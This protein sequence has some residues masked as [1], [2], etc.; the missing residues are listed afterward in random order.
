MKLSRQLL[1]DGLVV[2]A[3]V[4][5]SSLS[6]A[7]STPI[8]SANRKSGSIVTAQKAEGAHGSSITT[9]PLH[10]SHGSSGQ[11]PLYEPKDKAAAKPGRGTTEAQPYKDPEDMT[12]R[13][14]P[15]NN[16]TTRTP[17]NTATQGAGSQR[18]DGS[19]IHSDFPRSADRNSAHATESL[20]PSNKA[21]TG[22]NPLYEGGG[23]SGTNPLHESGKRTSA[24]PNTSTPSGVKQ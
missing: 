22:E 8:N 19:I 15:G 2:A 24:K 6:I 17:N 16:K 10:E 11:N 14:R 20:S 13:Y 1:S 3:L 12:T 9:N 21:R 7:Q 23:K 4:F 18:K 5:T